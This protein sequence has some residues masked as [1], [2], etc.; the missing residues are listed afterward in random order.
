[1]DKNIIVTWGL[2]KFK[3]KGHQMPDGWWYIYAPF[4]DDWHFV[5]STDV[6]LN[7]NQLHK[8]DKIEA[9]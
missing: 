2:R 3:T 6:M 5:P 1:M 7:W 8:G 4:D 9:C